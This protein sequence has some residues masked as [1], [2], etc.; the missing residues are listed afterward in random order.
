L[1]YFSVFLN[2]NSFFFFFL[3]CSIRV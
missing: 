3:F 1:L 2:S